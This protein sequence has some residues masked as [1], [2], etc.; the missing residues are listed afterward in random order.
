MYIGI[1]VKYPVMLVA[2][3]RNL[4]FHDEYLKNPSNFMEIRPVWAQLFDVDR[5]TD[6]TKLTVAFRNFANAPK[7][8]L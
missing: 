3:W 1:R 7:N 4:K 5:Q 6:M 2:F 8:K